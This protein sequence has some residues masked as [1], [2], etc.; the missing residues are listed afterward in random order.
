MNNGN[1]G[2]SFEDTQALLQKIQCFQST[3]G[4]DWSSVMSQWQNLQNSWKDSQYDR[5]EPLFE[6]L[7]R[8]YSELEHQQDEYIEFLQNRLR[9]AEDAAQIMNL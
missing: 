8:T 3:I 9:S 7:A 4:N 6:Q 1:V 2:I 5:F